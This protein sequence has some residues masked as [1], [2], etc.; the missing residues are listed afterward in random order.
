[1]EMLTLRKGATRTVLVLGPLALKFARG[2]RGRRSNRFEV[3]LYERVNL[4]RRAMLC[5]VL[6]CSQSGS[7][8][9]ARAARPLTLEER[10]RLWEIEGFPDWDYVP[11][12]D[13]GEPFEYKPSDWGV[14][15]GRLIALDYAAP[16]LFE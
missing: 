7:L 8:I 6:W 2:E 1:M 9:V 10:D 13:E 16:A 11:P 15:K 12:N 3:D 4:R 5:P 14:L